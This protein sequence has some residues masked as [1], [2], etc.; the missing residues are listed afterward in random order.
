MAR[1]KLWVV[2]S[3]IILV[4]ILGMEPALAQEPYDPEKELGIVRVV[5]TPD[6]V[7]SLFQDG[8][9]HYYAIRGRRNGFLVG[10]TPP[11][12]RND[13]L[14]PRLIDSVR[15]NVNVAELY[16]LG[17]G[18][19]RAILYEDGIQIDSGTFAGAGPVGSGIIVRQDRFTAETVPFPETA[20]SSNLPTTSTSPSTASS[21]D[22]GASDRAN[23]SFDGT[24]YTVVSGDNLFRIA[25]RF[26]T[27]F[28]ALMRLNNIS[29]A[30]LI[31]A[32]QRL[33]IR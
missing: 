29:N 17:G 15:R 31:Y 32:G 25:L 6:F 27:T 8:T 5:G 19:Y 3:C 23:G 14:S 18:E 22:K 10:V 2:L 13:T 26:N 4:G 33:R 12:W 9:I 20:P 21:G 7:V 24:F 11:G 30:N 16:N 28:G 1:V